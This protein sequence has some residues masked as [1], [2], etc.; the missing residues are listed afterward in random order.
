MTYLKEQIFPVPVIHHHQCYTVGLLSRLYSV[1]FVIPGYHRGDSRTFRYLDVIPVL[2]T[3]PS[4]FYMNCMN[5][6]CLPISS[7]SDHTVITFII[8]ILPRL[9]HYRSILN[10]A[11]LYQNELNTGRTFSIPSYQLVNSTSFSMVFMV[12]SEWL[13]YNEPFDKLI[14]S[15]Y[16]CKCSEIWSLQRFWCHFL[17]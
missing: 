12:K 9:I 10:C 16:C 7:C 11:S 5:H 13:F 2:S 3:S 1:E 14:F 4:W 6:K 15:V 8:P 17:C